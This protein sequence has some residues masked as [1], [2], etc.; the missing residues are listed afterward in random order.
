MKMKMYNYTETGIEY[1]QTK[2]TFWY[3]FSVCPE[4]GKKLS[5]MNAII[6]PHDYLCEE[7]YRDCE[8]YRQAVDQESNLRYAR[9]ILRH[10]LGE[11]DE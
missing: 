7:C 5:P 10:R 9:S 11:Q 2:L 4:C 6:V 8:R 1:M 3:E